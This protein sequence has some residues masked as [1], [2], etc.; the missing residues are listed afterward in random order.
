MRQGRLFT[1]RHLSAALSN[2]F[3]TPA[4]LSRHDETAR[5]SEPQF[6]ARYLGSHQNT[7]PICLAGNINLHA[8]DR[9][10]RISYTV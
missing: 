3:V 1:D 7:S 6:Q 2:L 4:I 5:H 10:I 8:F 9:T